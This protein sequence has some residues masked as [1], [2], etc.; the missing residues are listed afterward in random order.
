[1]SLTQLG[2]LPNAQ[3][4][5]HFFSSFRGNHNLV[6]KK[7]GFDTVNKYKYWDASKR[8]VD[9]EGLVADL[10]AA[11][12]HSVIILHGCAHNPTGMDPTREQWNRIAEVMKKKNHF[13]FFDIAYQGFASGDP[14]ADAWAIRYFVEQGLEMVIAQSFA[15]NFGLYSKF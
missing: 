6:F 1:M 13:T 12:E 14:D 10:E 15:K 3:C 2:K 8:Q 7:A 5:T 9:I 11:P 4:L